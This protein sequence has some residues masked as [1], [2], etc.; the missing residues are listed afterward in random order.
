MT[1][2]QYKCFIITKTV[3]SLWPLTYLAAVDRDDRKADC[4]LCY[5]LSPGV[6]WPAI[7]VTLPLAAAILA[8]V[9]WGKEGG[10]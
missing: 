8:A 4:W 2:H 9:L 7:S 3:S 5:I 10:K 6:T 1:Y